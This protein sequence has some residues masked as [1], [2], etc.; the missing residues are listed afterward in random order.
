MCVG[1]RPRSPVCSPA[2]GAKEDR[3]AGRA[4]RAAGFGALALCT[5]PCALRPLPHLQS[6]SPSSLTSAVPL[7]TAFPRTM[8]VISPPASSSACAQTCICILSS[9]H[10]GVPTS[11]PSPG[12]Q[13]H[14]W[15]TGSVSGP[16]SVTPDLRKERAGRVHAGPA[17]SRCWLRPPGPSRSSWGVGCQGQTANEDLLQPLW[18]WAARGAAGPPVQGRVPHGQAVLHSGPRAPSLSRVSSPRSPEMLPRL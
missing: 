11:Q 17:G 5:F 4:S 15:V 10:P 7:T 16:L 1:E 12:Q 6:A 14:S 2:G 3:K 13:S 18:G 9:S 8:P